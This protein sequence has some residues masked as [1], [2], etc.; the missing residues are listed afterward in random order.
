[1]THQTLPPINATLNAASAILLITA[2][3]FV[4]RRSYRVHASLTISAFLVSSVFLV[5][6]LYHKHLLHEATG[7]YNTSTTHVRP[8]ALRYF[9]LLVLL[10]PHLVLA[11]VMVP[12]ILRTFYLAY[13][14]RWDQHR[15]LAWP[16]LAIWLYVSV[17]GVVIYW[18]L[19]HLFPTMS[20]P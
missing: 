4:K 9:Y 11:I 3:V 2:L 19:Y 20:S 18:M 15:K 12:L 1:M 7:S 17:T 13:R 6:Y 16:T 5:L 10:L 14:R 8:V